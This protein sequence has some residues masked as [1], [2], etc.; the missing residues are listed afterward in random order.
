MRAI[1]LTA[2]RTQL[3]FVVVAFAGILNTR[4][5]RSEEAG[6]TSRLTVP[7]D[8]AQ[9]KA[10]QLLKEVYK[11]YPPKTQATR[12]E[13]AKKLNAAA[14]TSTDDAAA[15]YVLFREAGEL[16]ASAGDFDA[17][18]R[19]WDEMGKRFVM[20]SRAIKIAGLKSVRSSRM[21]VSSAASASAAAIAIGW[22]AMRSGDFAMASQ[23][24]SLAEAFAAQTTDKKTVAD[25]QALSGDAGRAAQESKRASAAAEKLRTDPNDPP[26]NRVVGRFLCLW[27]GRW[28][29]GLPLLAKSDDSV[30]KSVASADAADPP[31]AAGQFAL[32]EQWYAIS[33]RES[34]T[35]RSRLRERAQH[36]YSR[37][38][39]GL[40]GLQQTLARRR[41]AEIEQAETSNSLSNSP[42]AVLT[43][44]FNDPSQWADPHGKWQ[45]G[46]GNLRG[47]GPT[48][49][50]FAQPLPGNIILSFRINVLSGMRPRIFFDGTGMMYG[51]EGYA[52]GLNPFGVAVT[53]GGNVPYENNQPHLL[54]FNFS[55]GHYE[56]DVDGKLAAKGTCAA[57][58]AIKLRIRGGDD[59]SP[60]TTEFWDFRVESASPSATP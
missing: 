49:I 23:A 19:A 39:P 45:V 37:A 29:S 22:D 32:A 55:A 30:L 15:Q 27:Q 46:A 50:S 36:W 53:S 57:A 4:L 25:S 38:V 42:A 26:S 44:Q 16:S 14:Q 6:D 60:G 5:L 18:M 35:I 48:E 11:P 20:D 7:S 10:F 40:N 24:A 28:D 13:L 21:N 54:R 34:A 2:S 1:V 3:L 52:K 41:L 58:P 17:A 9:K 33:A 12:A 56:V 51:N 59:W 43:R 47:E 31:A 8:A